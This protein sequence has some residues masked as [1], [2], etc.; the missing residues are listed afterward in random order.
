MSTILHI[1]QNR[2]LGV[3][4]SHKI[5]ASHFDNKH[6]YYNFI[7]NTNLSMLSSS[8]NVL[9]LQQ[10][11]ILYSN[12]LSTCILLSTHHHEEKGKHTATVY[13]ILSTVTLL[14]EA[15]AKSTP[16]SYFKERYA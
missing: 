14:L 10:F 12:L 1:I 4:Y 7:C 8:T 11:C 15:F 2:I 6:L 16:K 3:E 13:L 9:L 5:C